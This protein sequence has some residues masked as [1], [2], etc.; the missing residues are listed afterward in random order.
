MRNAKGSVYQRKDGTWIT[1]ISMGNDPGTGKR[2]RRYYQFQTERQAIQKLNEI[3]YERDNDEYIEPSKMTVAQWLDKWHSDFVMDVKPGTLARYESVI[4]V[5]LKPNLGAVRLTALDTM[6][7]QAFYNKKYRSGL[8]AKTISVI[9]GVLHSAMKK[10]LR[11]GMVKSNPTE[12][13]ELPRR[14]RPEL[15]PL[16]DEQIVDFVKAIKGHPLEALFTFTLFSGCRLSEVIGLT[17]SAVD[18]DNGIVRI[19]RQYL[20]NPDN[21]SEFYFASLKN[22]KE[23]SLTLPD[24]ITALLKQHKKKQAEQRLKAGSLWSNPN[25]FCFTNDFGKHLY[26]NAIDRAAKKIFET[27]GV[28]NCR[29][30]DLR[31][32]Y[33]CLAL[34]N[35]DDL[36]TVS[37]NLGH[38]NISITADV[39]AFA[40]QKM[41]RDSSQRMD[42]FIKSL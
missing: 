10:A 30:H 27:I 14:K 20:R 28:P 24:S 17:W 5:H 12:A 32:S 18:L 34:Q 23:R 16:H 22:G 2:K 6:T 35:G 21:T 31:H 9:H 8:S 19:Y 13:C 15:T 36:K 26:P 41:K 4:R 37:E 33:A 25:E 1:A 3:N 29:Y 40:S 11:L 7:V 38:S 39:Y 42:A